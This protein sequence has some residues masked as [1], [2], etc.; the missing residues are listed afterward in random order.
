MRWPVVEYAMSK[1]DLKL[2]MRYCKNHK[3]LT[4]AID[5]HM[6]FVADFYVTIVLF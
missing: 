4:L 2:K 3:N 5:K 6:A 1:T